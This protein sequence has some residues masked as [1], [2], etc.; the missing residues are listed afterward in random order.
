MTSTSAQKASLI[1][2]SSLT[3]KR[4]E[5]ALRCSPFQL[6]LFSTMIKQSVALQEITLTKGQQKGYTYRAIS[7]TLA[8]KELMWLIKVGILRR[9]VDGQGITD[10]F[11][12]TPLG[13]EIIKQS[14]KQ[15]LD[16][17]KA[18]ILDYI[19]NTFNRWLS[20]QF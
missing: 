13:R 11:R 9:E 6:D 17:A 1:P 19:I 2:Y 12:L 3:F 5:R 16:F 8:E 10:S 15:S 20:W 7:E 4:G 14:E 18:S